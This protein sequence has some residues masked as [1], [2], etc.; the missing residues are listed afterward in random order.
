MKKAFFATALLTGTV[1]LF[2]AGCLAAEKD[3]QTYA[4]TDFAMDTVVTETLY[5]TGDDINSKLTSVLTDVETDL[6]SWT[7]EKSQIYKINVDSGKDTE[8]S[9]ELSG[10]LERI[11][12]IAKDSD[13]AFDPTIGKL[14]RLWDIGGEDQKIPEESEIQE[15]LKDSGYKKV[16]L[17]GNTIQMDAGCSLDLGAAGK[18]IG[19]DSVLEYL[20]E[21]KEVSA[22]LMNLGGSSVMTYG[23]KP[24]GSSWNVAVTDPRAENKD[25]YLGVVAL[26][27]TEFLS[28]SGDY[29]LSLIHI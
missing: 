17:T 6:L 11:L 12:K 26:N 7:N 3:I 8:I 21:Q 27:G 14:I 10:Y 28:T 18:G 20:K 22:A 2:P 29:E 15:I 23:S 16:S 25:N 13:G 9:E 1:M 19:C 5:T 4:D 24:D